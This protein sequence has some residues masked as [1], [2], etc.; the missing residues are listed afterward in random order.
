MAKLDTLFNNF[1]LLL[2]SPNSIQKI[3]ELILQLAVQGKLVPQDINDEPAS[4]LLKKIKAEK[5]KLIAEGKIKK[6]KP[7]PPIKPEELPYE[8][9]KG[10]EWVRLGDVTEVNPRNYI[11]DDLDVSFIPMN[12]IDDGFKNN[13]F[14]ETRKWAEIKSGFTHLKEDD[15]AVAKITPCFQNRKSAVMKNLKNGYGAGTTELYVIRSYDRTIVPGFLLSCCKTETF[16]QEG[17]RTFK[18]TAGQQRVKKDYVE[19][20][21][22]GLPPH[23]EQIRIAAKIDDLMKL[24]DELESQLRRFQKERELL[25][26]AVLQE[27]FQKAI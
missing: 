15:V 4:E 26:Q 18:G 10:W 13:H 27:A 22:I 23:N 25:M 5:E 7:L 2:D 1:D 9:P 12:L 8:L 16:I 21:I 11:A 19:G 20:L 14:S 17:V 3:R 24:C 6:E